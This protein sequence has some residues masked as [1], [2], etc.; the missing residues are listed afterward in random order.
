MYDTNGNSGSLEQLYLLIDRDTVL[1]LNMLGVFKN[2]VKALRN[3]YLSEEYDTE[4][5]S[6]TF[7]AK[8]DTFLCDLMCTVHKVVSG[9][10]CTTKYLVGASQP[11]HDFKSIKSL[12]TS[13]SPLS[14]HDTMCLLM[15]LPA[16]TTLKC[17][18]NGLGSGFAHVSM[19][20]LPDYIASLYNK[21]GRF[22]NAWKVTSFSSESQ[23]MDVEYVMLLALACPR[24]HRVMLMKSVIPDFSAKI[25]EALHSD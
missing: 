19:G 1:K 18:T 24:L 25:S 10:V 9:T 13:D 11:E 16:L 14:L 22:L 17:G 3:V 5:L 23:S 4:D 2:R 6:H 12:D 21:A 15:A 20:E 7:K 8:L